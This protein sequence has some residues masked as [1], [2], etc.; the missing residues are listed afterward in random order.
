LESVEQFQ[1]YIVK[2]LPQMIVTP[3][4]L[5]FTASKKEPGTE[6]WLFHKIL[7]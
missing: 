1:A 4:I 5:L 3:E 6:N 2:F 7:C